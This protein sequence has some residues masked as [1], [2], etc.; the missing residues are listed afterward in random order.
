MKPLLLKVP[1][2]ADHS[3]SIRKDMI[4]NINNRWHYHEEVELIHFHQGSGTQFVGD[5][6]MQFEAGDIVLIGANL[7]HYWKYDTPLLPDNQPYSTVIHFFEN[8]WGDRLLQLP[9][10]KTIKGI[11]E[12]AQRGLLI[13]GAA[14][15]EAGALIEKIYHAG[16]IIRITAL[17]ECLLCFVNNRQCIT[18]SSMGFNY[19]LSAS[20]SE[21]LDAIYNFTL[22]NFCHKISL[23][24]IAAIA[25]MAP[26]SF[27]RYFKSRTGKSY[28]RFLLELRIGYACKLLLDNR[29]SLKQIAAAS[30]FNNLSGFHAGFKEITQK[31]PLEYQA[32]Y[33]K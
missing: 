10:A 28:S 31:T 7:P 4:P 20:E 29:Q 16:D 32:A 2:V 8:F 30:G 19:H 18:L 13:K 26:N 33:L 5:H 25:L 6:I 15:K 3:F 12:K 24:D 9:E 23:K 1:R 17:L 22:A 11:L 21:R 27:C 14:A